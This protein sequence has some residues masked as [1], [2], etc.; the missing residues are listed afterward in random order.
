MKMQAKL[1]AA[2]FGLAWA[3]GAGAQ[4]VEEAFHA[5]AGDYS[6]CMVATVRM[7][8]TTR[9]DPAV[10]KAGLEKSC[11]AEEAKFRAAAVAQARALG[12]TESE[13]AAEV[14]GNIARGKAAWA[15]DQASYISTG[16]VPR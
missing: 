1:L 16:R 2:L 6:A 13:A 9:M 14:D 3:G 7:G 12:R 5:A 10:F 4:S 15:A 11:P 8:M